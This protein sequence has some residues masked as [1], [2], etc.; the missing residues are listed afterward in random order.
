M[1]KFIYMPNEIKEP[2]KVQSSET[3]KAAVSAIEAGKSIESQTEVKNEMASAMLEKNFFPTSQADLPT[4]LQP[5]AAVGAKSAEIL[6]VENILEED[7]ADLYVKMNK[8]TQEKFKKVGEETAL[9]IAKILSQAK[10]QVKKIFDLIVA[11]L[12]IIPGLN[13][14]FLEQEAKIK[15]DRILELEKQNYKTDKNKYVNTRGSG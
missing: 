14:F 1:N 15:T 10:Y 6:R 4:I 13:Q 11:W 12:K 7:L 8:P 5:S 9:N 2:S 3:E